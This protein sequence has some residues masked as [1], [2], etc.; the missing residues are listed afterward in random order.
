MSTAR[1]AS[2]AGFTIVETLIVVAIAGL[3]LLLVLEALPALQ[4]SSRNNQRRQDIQTV[5]AATSHYELN[6]A[7]TIPNAGQLQLFLNTYEKGKLTFYDS[8]NIDVYTPLATDNS[9][10]Y[11]S[12]PVAP[13]D[14]LI[15]NHAKCTAN[16][17][18]SNQGAGYS[19]VVA[20]YS[21]EAG[22]GTSPQCQQL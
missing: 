8:S 18:A 11:P 14:I 7:G 21:I 15:N 1:N 10:T 2:S 20:L 19:D 6:H 12:A 13:D 22:G 3:I 5:L 17:N 4:R 9:Q 16:G